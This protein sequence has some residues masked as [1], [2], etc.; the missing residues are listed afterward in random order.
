MRA[1]SA[2]S[3]IDLVITVVIIA[4]IAAIAVPRLSSAIS[5]SQERAVANDL[6]QLVEAAYRYYTENGVYPEAENNKALPSEITGQFHSGR[7]ESGTPIGGKWQYKVSEG[8]PCVVL[9][10]NTSDTPSE[11]F[12][13]AVDAIVDD[14]DLNSGAKT[15]TNTKEYTYQLW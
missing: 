7:W 6:N 5:A 12:M 9:K 15:Q 1:Q 11:E 10:F 8:I 4:V 2:F 3:L 13:E 14:G